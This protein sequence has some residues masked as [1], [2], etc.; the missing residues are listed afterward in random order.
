[1][2]LEDNKMD[3]LNQ[4]KAYILNTYKRMDLC[5]DKIRGNYIYTTDG[6]KYL[7]FFS[8]IAV[9]NLGYDEDVIQAMIDKMMRYTHISNYFVDEDRA[10]LAKLLIENSINGKVFFTN[11]GTESTEAAL[12]L[13]KKLGNKNNKSK[14]LTALNSFH[15][16]TTGA[17]AL[18]GQKKYQFDFEPLIGNVEHFIF[19]DINSLLSMVDNNTSAVFIEPVQGEGGVIPLSR[20]FV[21]ELMSL[22]KKYNFI[23]VIDEIQTGFR[24]CN[25][26]FAYQNYKIEPDI[27]LLAKSLG[28]GLPLGAMIVAEQYEHV[29][30]IGDH[31]STF[32]GN[33]VACA[34]GLAV[35]KKLTN[36]EFVHTIIEN[37]K[38]MYSRFQGIQSKFPHIIKDLRGISMMLGI[39]AGEHAATIKDRAVNEGILLNI[40]N[41]TV[42]RI[43]PPLTVT[44]D[45][46]DFCADALEKIIADINVL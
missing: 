8:G 39:D 19:N 46:I 31:G 22:K 43:I 37:S 2:I 1:M 15:G 35:L 6:R 45:E 30:G 20:E 25:T 3:M 27:I 42:I 26:L 23:L 4:D 24:R 7:D 34:G 10:E 14:I 28:G 21:E 17:L 13:V 36:E 44:A 32:G 40:T 29:L 38:Y 12:K 16:R 18:T 11:S 41:K 5:I 33:P 9:N